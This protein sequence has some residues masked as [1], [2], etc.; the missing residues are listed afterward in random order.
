MKVNP[1]GHV[2]AERSRIVS[3]FGLKE[4]AVDGVRY[5]GDDKITYVKQS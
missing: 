5:A 4:M 1:L 3:K 2:K